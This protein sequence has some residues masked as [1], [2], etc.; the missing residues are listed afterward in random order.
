[1]AMVFKVFLGLP[2]HFC[3]F[4]MFAVVGVAKH[5]FADFGV[6]LYLFYAFL[7]GYFV[8]II[9]E[10]REDKISNIAYYQKIKAEKLRVHYKK[11]FF[12][13]N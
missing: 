2:C 11:K 6:T 7:F 8:A 12:R 5:L 4:R 10:S 1:M 9:I 13:A 3:S